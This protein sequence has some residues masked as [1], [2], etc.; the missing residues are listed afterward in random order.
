MIGLDVLVDDDGK[1]WR[2]GSPALLRSL[3]I[4]ER[5]YDLTS[6]L[7]RNLGFARFRAQRAAGRIMV[8]PRFLTKATYESLVHV[9]IQNDVERF[10]IETIDKLKLVEIIP[11]LEDAVAYLGDLAALGGNVTRQDFYCEPLSL[12]RL[13][14]T[15]RLSPLGTLLRRWRSGGGVIRANPADELSDPALRGR[16]L[17]IRVAS[18]DEVVTE[19]IGEGFQW[20]TAPMRSAMLGSGASRHPDPGYG[21]NALVSYQETDRT[22]TPRLE[23]VDAVIRVAGCPPSRKRYE[24]LL[25]PWT[26]GSARFVS[27]AS[28]LR[29]S[30]AATADV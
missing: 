24:R 6:Y 1:I 16:T 8:Q 18:G 20:I 19:H 2:T 9:M 23:V 10:V 22:Q 5:D 17:M 11:D 21:R 15:P 3:R 29:A 13:V 30:F 27:V 14:R 26:S 25:L 12:Q 4:E 28:V 7:V